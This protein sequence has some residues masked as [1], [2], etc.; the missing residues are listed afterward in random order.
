MPRPEAIINCQKNMCSIDKGDQMRAHCGG[1]S[2]KAHCKKWHKKG[3]FAVH[4]M[5]LTNSLTS[6]NIASND[7]PQLEPLVLSGHDMHWH[8]GQR[9]LNCTEQVPMCRSPEKLQAASACA[10]GHEPEKC[11]PKST[12]AVCKIDWNLER[13]KL[14]KE[15][16]KAGL[17]SDVVMCRGCATIA[18]DRPCQVTRTTHGSPE[19][20]GPT[21]FEIAHTTK[22]FHLWNPNQEVQATDKEEKKRSC[23]PKTSHLTCLELA[24]R[25]GAAPKKCSASAATGTD[26]S[27]PPPSSSSEDE[28]DAKPLPPCLTD[29]PEFTNNTST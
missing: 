27:Q 5:V 13:K 20:Q 14:G 7:N 1:F 18:H 6:W 10:K 23:N 12:C 19:F 24:K 4:D 15:P 29:V 22:G 3:F 17:T 25:I 11:G 26:N 21:C 28:E 8:I 16:P 9:V 2:S